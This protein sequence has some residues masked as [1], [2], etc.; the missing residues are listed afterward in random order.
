MWIGLREMAVE[1]AM[2]ALALVEEQGERRRE[3][4]FRRCGDEVRKPGGADRRSD[5]FQVIVTERGRRVQGG[6]LVM[7]P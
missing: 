2:L 1:H 5:A 3:R 4:A 6:L 7:R